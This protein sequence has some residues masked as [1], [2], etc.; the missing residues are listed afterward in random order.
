MKARRQLHPVP[1]ARE[2]LGNIGHSK[3]YEVVRAG[4][5][6]LVKIG[7]RSFVT[8]DELRRFVRSLEAN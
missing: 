3:F 6:R 4:E 7:R 8:D 1:E 2:I 5:L